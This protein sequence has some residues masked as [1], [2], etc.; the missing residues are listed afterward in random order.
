[1]NP[2]RLPA[3]RTTATIMRIFFMDLS[4]SGVTPFSVYAIF[5]CPVPSN[6]AFRLFSH[7]RSIAGSARLAGDGNDSTDACRRNSLGS[8]A[9]KNGSKRRLEE[10]RCLL[11]GADAARDAKLAPEGLVRRCRQGDFPASIPSNLRGKTPFAIILPGTVRTR[12]IE[13][14]R[15]FNRR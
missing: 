1:M 2:I 5:G 8:A 10:L 12:R 14:F 4:A 13:G 6:G 15:S 9:I 3:T 11:D 7:S